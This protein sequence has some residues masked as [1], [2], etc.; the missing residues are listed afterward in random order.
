[1]EQQPEISVFDVNPPD[2]SQSETERRRPMN[3]E[4]ISEDTT[5]SHTEA[6]G[7]EVTV[8]I[9]APAPSTAP[10]TAPNNHQGANQDTLSL[11]EV[12]E[13]QDDSDSDYFSD[14]NENALSL[15]EVDE[16]QDDSDYSYHTPGEELSDDDR[17]GINYI[18]DS[19]SDNDSDSDMPALELRSDSDYSNSNMTQELQGLSEEAAAAA[20]VEA[21]RLKEEAA[22]KKQKLIQAAFDT[23][24]MCSICICNFEK[25]EE[26]RVLPDCGHAFH[27]D[28]IMPWLTEKKNTCP[29]C[30]TKVRKNVKICGE[31]SSTG[32]DA[33]NH[34]RRQGGNDSENVNENENGADSVSDMASGLREYGLRELFGI[35][36]QYDNGPEGFNVGPPAGMMPRRVTNTNFIFGP[37][38]SSNTATNAGAD[39]DGGGGGGGYSYSSGFHGEEVD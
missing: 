15:S 33:R 31:S 29:L 30:L 24:T 14:A 27:T 34:H 8:S 13:D 36:S 18:D 2:M 16:D 1:L 35:L 23:C 28:C 17:Q 9:S 10:S 21:K 25:G 6:Q 32:D 19:D 20:E 3:Q 22:K 12:D 38:G 26:L 4:V 7:A 5:R 39:D 37:N 11:S